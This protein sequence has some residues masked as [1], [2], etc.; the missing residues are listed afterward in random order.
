[1]LHLQIQLQGELRPMDLTADDKPG[2]ELGM[3]YVPQRLWKQRDP[4]HQNLSS[5]T[6]KRRPRDMPLPP[7]CLRSSRL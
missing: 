4:A 3:G 2:G 1:M 6:E 5:E 7:S